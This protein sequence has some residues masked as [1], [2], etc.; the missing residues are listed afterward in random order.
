MN[1]SN[2][3]TELPR[4]LRTAR[5]L[6]RR[7]RSDDRAPFAA[8]NADPRVMEHFPG[9]M[10]REASD[11][12][13]DRFAAHF[14]QHGFG[15]W[16]VEIVGGPPFAGFV[17]LSI[18]RFEAAFTPR[19]EIGWRLAAE[20]WGQ[21]YATEGARSA[22]AFGFETLGLDEIVSFTVPANLRSR[23]VMEKIGM[24]YDRQ[25]DFAHPRLPAGHPLSLHVLYRLRK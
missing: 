24:T 3:P 6:L 7:W 25:G 20:C 10:S 18:P 23:R 1:H 12:A 13:A 8:M 15:L 5:L 19:V 14:E 2:M 9:L 11:A 16:A 22:L 21:G 4:E 17:G